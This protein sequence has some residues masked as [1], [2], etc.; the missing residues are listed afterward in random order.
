MAL[1]DYLD[2]P[3]RPRVRLDEI[4]DVLDPGE[5][6]ELVSWLAD[7]T[8]ASARIAR[9]LTRA[10]SAKGVA[11][12]IGEQAVREARRNGWAPQ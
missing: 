2:A 3:A 12:S 6:E 8:L 1:A 4:Y 11:L 5:R 7:E 9:G 10:M